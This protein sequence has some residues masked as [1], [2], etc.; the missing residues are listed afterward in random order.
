M[1]CIAI[2]LL[3]VIELLSVL[4]YGFIWLDELRFSDSRQRESQQSKLIQQ[5]TSR[6]SFFSVSGSTC[7]LSMLRWIHAPASEHLHTVLA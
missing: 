7:D 3:I 1:L 4:F 2:L 5:S 6:P